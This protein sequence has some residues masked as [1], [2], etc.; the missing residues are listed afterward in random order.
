MKKFNYFLGTL[1]CLLFVIS[2]GY[3]QNLFEEKVYNSKSLIENE[4]ESAVLSTCNINAGGSVSYCFDSDTIGL[5]GSQS[6]IDLSTINWTLLSGPGSVSIT[7][8]NSL[9]TSFVGTPLKLGTY[10]FKISGTCIDDGTLK[11]FT[12]QITILPPVTPAEI[13]DASGP[14]L[15]DTIT[16]CTDIQLIGNSPGIG[17]TG[18]WSVASEPFNHS[19][20]QL[21]DTLNARMSPSVFCNQV[22]Y[23]YTISNEGCVSIDTITVIYER[24]EQNVQIENGDQSICGDTIRVTGSY[25]GCSTSSTTSW[26]II[27][28][29]GESV[30]NFTNFGLFID[31]NFTVSG[32]YQIIYN[33]TS[34]G[35]CSGG[36]DTVTYNVCLSS[37]NGIGNNIEI[38]VCDS[39]PDTLFLTSIVDPTYTY[40]NWTL[41]GGF[42]TPPVNIVQTT[43]GQ[44]YALIYDQT[45]S[46]Y[47]F[48]I[49]A[50]ADTCKFSGSGS[51]IC[52]ASR[53]ITL[54]KAR[55]FDLEA[56][57]L[58]IFCQVPG[59]TYKPR[60]YISVS[61]SG[62]NIFDLE[63]LQVPASCLS[64]INGNTYQS[65]QSLDFSCEGTYVFRATYSRKIGSDY[66]NDTLIWTV[67]VR[68]L[69]KPSAGSDDTTRV[70]DNDTIPLV[71]ST[72]ID[73]L[74]NPQLW[75]EATWNQIDTHPPVQ[76]LGSV[77]DQILNATGFTQVGTYMFEYSFS[78]SEDC[79]LADTMIV[80]V[81]S[82]EDC[83]EFFIYTCCDLEGGIGSKSGGSSRR[84]TINPLVQAKITAY[85][86]AVR[87]RYP[88]KSLTVD[89]CCMYCEFPE[90]PFP[91]FIYDE[92]GDLVNTYTNPIVW[93]HHGPPYNAID[94]IHTDSLTIV[95]VFGPGTCVWSDT[96]LLSCCENP[97]NSGFCCDDFDLD[98]NI[99][100][101]CATDPCDTNLLNYPLFVRLNGGGALGY[102]GYYFTWSTGSHANQISIPRGAQQVWVAIY[103]STAGCTDTAFYIV[104][105]RISPLCIPIV[106]TNLSCD[107]RGGIQKLT[108]LTSIGFTYQVEI[109]YDDPFCVKGG[110]GSLPVIY[111]VSG[112]SFT[113]PISSKTGCLSWRVRSVCS[114]GAKSS[115]SAK[116]CCCIKTFCFPVVPTNLTCTKLN[117][118]SS[119]SWN[120]ILGSTYEVSI[121]YND[122][123]CCR[124]GGPGIVTN[125]YTGNS[126]HF[127]SGCF[128]WKVRSIC[129]DG[130]K[131]A[132]STTACSCSSTII[133]SKSG[134]RFRISTKKNEGSV[135]FENEMK[136]TLSPNPTRDY[137]SFEVSTPNASSEMGK[138]EITSLTGSVVYSSK[139]S[140]NGS[141]L[142]DLSHLNNGTYFYRIIS[143]NEFKSGRIVVSD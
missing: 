120:Q 107:T 111:N 103:D 37:A 58:N 21:G 83:P 9:T 48:S 30:P 2:I 32:S 137:V 59:T 40:G 23:F 78:R 133:D 99:D 61:G 135:V 102:S 7:N 127:T 31:V 19:W 41:S 131:S 46:Q 6:G 117:N 4:T 33:V 14:V 13:S 67:N 110:T 57:T 105:C 27:P 56:D 34:N 38:Y 1:F 132:W 86:R 114:N 72:A 94:S 35:V 140:L 139:I 47:Y 75:V 109:I 24:V 55:S 128:S 50:A 73:L 68:T 79:Y 101:I 115:W 100:S 104:N 17:E 53:E 74:G 16:A 26:Q 92:N 118:G 98:L 36:S 52:E 119:L 80:V 54:R 126:T 76:F 95:T 97:G 63:A 65:Y 113:V 15:T 12:V 90:V 10:V 93:S 39:F 82:C 96:F 64:I 44:G 129:P 91:I 20:S 85:N 124:K 28:P 143:D 84:P 29:S 71:G 22:T 3:S 43:I 8:A 141:T 136:V 106:P 121:Y 81:D 70:C 45:R 138:I 142:I 49:K 11:T 89:S 18:V 125:V 42:G 108:W 122:P 5:Y 51:V 25:A 116:Q 77:H 60:N 123:Q 62:I 134:T 112:G 88:I 130:T 87:K 69:Q 66:C